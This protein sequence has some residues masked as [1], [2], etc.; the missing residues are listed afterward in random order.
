VCR[1]AWLGASPDGVTLSGRLVEIKCPY[2]RRVSLVGLKAKCAPARARAR[3]G[4]GL[5]CRGVAHQFATR[6]KLRIS[7]RQAFRVGDRSRGRFATPAQFPLHDCSPYSHV[8]ARREILGFVP[9]SRTICC[10]PVPNPNPLR[11]NIV[12]AVHPAD[13]RGC[14]ARRHYA[15]VQVSLE[16]FN[17]EVCDL[18]QYYKPTGGRAQRKFKVRS[19]GP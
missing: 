13:P 8:H 12:I 16:I 19:S 15:Q 14:I 1:Y 10:R 18:V 17:L 2:N 3:V 6:I 7:Q 4:L 11:F 5:G 9:R